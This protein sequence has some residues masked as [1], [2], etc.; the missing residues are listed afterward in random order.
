MSDFS[1]PWTAA[2]QAPSSMG[3]SRQEYWSGVPSPSLV[4]LGYTFRNECTG[5]ESITVSQLVFRKWA[6]WDQPRGYIGKRIPGK[7]I[8]EDSL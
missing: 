8:P 7:V 6:V 3:F 2:Y 5:N 1:T 4:T